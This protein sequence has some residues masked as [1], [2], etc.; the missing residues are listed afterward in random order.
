MAKMGKKMGILC[1][2]NAG[3]CN[4]LGPI[5]APDTQNRRLETGNTLA[6]TL[7]C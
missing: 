5:P 3:Q 4:V 6:L 1:G 2:E 7:W